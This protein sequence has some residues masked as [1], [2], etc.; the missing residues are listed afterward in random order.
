MGPK[1]WFTFS[2]KKAIGISLYWDINYQTICFYFIIFSLEFN[3]SNNKS[4]YKEFFHF[5]NQI[6]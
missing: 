4:E 2:I 1:S 3:W 6:K 5:Y